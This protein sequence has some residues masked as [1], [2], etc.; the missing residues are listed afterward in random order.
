M[1]TISGGI[2]TYLPTASYS[3]LD[4][5]GADT[6]AGELHAWELQECLRATVCVEDDPPLHLEPG[7]ASARVHNANASRAMLD[8][9]RKEVFDRIVKDLWEA[10]DPF[11]ADVCGA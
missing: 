6:L 5:A 8:S 11:L 1:A 7:G 9:I 3:D 2:I 10:L 4:L